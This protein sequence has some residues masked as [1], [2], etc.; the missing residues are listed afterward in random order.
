MTHAADRLCQLTVYVVSK[1]SVTFQGSQKLC[2]DFRLWGAARSVPLPPCYLRVSS[3]AKGRRL[4]VS[5]GATNVRSHP[6]T[7]L[8]ASCSFR[9]FLFFLPDLFSPMGKDPHPVPRFTHQG[10]CR[11]LTRCSLASGFISLRP[12]LC[13]VASVLAGVVGVTSVPAVD[14][15]IGMIL[16]RFPFSRFITCFLGYFIKF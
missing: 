3:K 6:P 4:R 12:G 16:S 5:P 15:L 9:G 2:I 11:T 10:F 1:L 8:L 13:T 14:M 7:L